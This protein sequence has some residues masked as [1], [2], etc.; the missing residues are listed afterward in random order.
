MDIT[1]IL[2]EFF[3]KINENSNECTQGGWEFVSAK[4]FFESSPQINFK[5]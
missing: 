2:E 5:K 3:P 1:R 4:A